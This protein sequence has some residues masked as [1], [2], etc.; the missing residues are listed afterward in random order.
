VAN[1]APP[2]TIPLTNPNA[3]QSTDPHLQDLWNTA[4]AAAQTNGWATT[5]TSLMAISASQDLSSSQATVIR[6]SMNAVG[7]AMFT[8]ANGGDAAAATALA[9]VRG[10]MHHHQAAPQ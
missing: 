5:Y 2:G 10:G 6:N 3:F 4:I 7:M 8:A 9:Q 1:T